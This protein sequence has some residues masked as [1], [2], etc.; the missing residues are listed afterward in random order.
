MEGVVEEKGIL[1]ERS[2]WFRSRPDMFRMTPLLGLSMASGHTCRARQHRTCA[3]QALW[4]VEERGGH[5][6]GKIAPGIVCM[7]RLAPPRQNENIQ[8]G[9]RD[10]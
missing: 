3:V 4:G 9:R 2:E 1:P 6:R 7:L 8:E 10:T 5:D